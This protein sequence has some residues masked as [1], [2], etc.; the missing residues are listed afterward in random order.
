MKQAIK[1]I[2]MKFQ[3]GKKHSESTKFVCGHCESGETYNLI[4]LNAIQCRKCGEKSTME[5]WN[6]KTN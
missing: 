4:K 5:G 1:H 6:E 3:D 2:L